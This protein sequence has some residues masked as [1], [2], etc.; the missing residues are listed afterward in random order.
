M[1]TGSGKRG[2]GNEKRETRRPKTPPTTPSTRAGLA[3]ESQP[4]AASR[5]PLSCFAV[6]LFLSLFSGCATDYHSRG[7]L[8]DGYSEEDLGGD[9]WRVTFAVNFFTPRERIDTLLLFRCAELT[10]EKSSSYFLVV[11]GTEDDPSLK[12]FQPDLIDAPSWA[13]NAPQPAG[14]KPPKKKRT[15]AVVIKIFT[16]KPAGYPKVYDARELIQQLTPKMR[17]A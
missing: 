5:L 17:S 12:P 11:H 14:A 16:G 4:S 13:S 8:G 1:T 7:F 9:R 3:A 2:T 10:V 15:E 6:L